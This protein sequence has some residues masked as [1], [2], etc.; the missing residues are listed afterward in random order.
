MKNK[1]WKVSLWKHFG[2]KEK[3]VQKM[4]QFAML[5]GSSSRLAWFDRGWVSYHCSWNIN[6]RE[7]LHTHYFYHYQYDVNKSCPDII[8]MS[9]NRSTEI[10]ILYYKR[11]ENENCLRDMLLRRIITSEVLSSHTIPLF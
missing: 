2:M 10:S 11:R 7:W 9:W 1:V 4:Y 8:S 5:C 3:Q 6:Q